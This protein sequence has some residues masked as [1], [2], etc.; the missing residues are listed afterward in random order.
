MV[1]GGFHLVGRD[2]D[3]CDVWNWLRFQLAFSP[4]TKP[5]NH[6]GHGGARG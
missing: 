6:G 4:L 3:L 1:A 2:R 5:L